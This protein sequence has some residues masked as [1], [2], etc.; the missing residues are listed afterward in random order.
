MAACRISVR[1]S[2][3]AVNELEEGR[4][5]KLMILT[6]SIEVNGFVNT[7]REKMERNISW[8]YIKYTKSRAG[9]LPPPLAV[10]L[11]RQG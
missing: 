2:L 11:S 9:C 4:N 6:D 7:L 5:S 1:F 10:L 3:T 8:E